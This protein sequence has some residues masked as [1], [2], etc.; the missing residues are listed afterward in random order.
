[1]KTAKENIQHINTA[2]ITYLR[3][4]EAERGSS[5]L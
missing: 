5:L 2:K 4:I 3:D 1:M